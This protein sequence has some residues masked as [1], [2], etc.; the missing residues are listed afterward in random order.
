VTQPFAHFGEAMAILAAFIFAWTSVLFT[1]AGQRLGVTTVNLIRLPGAAVCLAVAHL[2][3]TGSPWPVGMS[4]ADHF[5]IGLSGVVGLAVG[6]SALFMAFT[7]IGPRRS[8]TMMALAPVFTTVIAWVVLGEHLNVWAVAGIVVVITGVMIAA[9]GRDGGGG[10]FGAI[11]PA[12]L[13]N[14]ILLAV[15]AA[16]GQGLGSVFAKMGMTGATSGGPGVDPLGA[17]LV[18]VVWA[19]VGYWSIMAPRLWSGGLVR[20][21]ADRRGLASLGGAI[22]LGPFISV[23]ISQVAIRH[24]EAGVAQVLLGMVP[25]FVIAPAWIVYRDRPGVLS[26]VGVTMAVAGSALLFLR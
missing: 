6:D 13:R 2:A 20:R 15:I 12:T 10:R 5:W 7:T 21:L 1:S 22:L 16:A 23:W 4:G 11:A 14:G 19:T 9:R 3:L 24:T 26:L 18:R 17:T 8:M 25:I